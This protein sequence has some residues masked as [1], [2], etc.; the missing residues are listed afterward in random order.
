MTIRRREFV[1]LAGAAALSGVLPR[2]HRF[3]D[4]GMGRGLRAARILA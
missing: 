4:M 3:K 1:T 2:L